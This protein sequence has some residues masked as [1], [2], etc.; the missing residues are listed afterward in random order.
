LALGS[1]SLT[2]VLLTGGPVRSGWIDLLLY[3]D[4]EATTGRPGAASAQVGSYLVASPIAFGYLNGR[5]V[6]TLG[7]PFTLRLTAEARAQSPQLVSWSQSASALV[8]FNLYEADGTPYLYGL[9]EAVPEPGGLVA[10]G[11]LAL[12][13]ARRW[14]MRVRGC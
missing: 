14:S 5:F 6:F 2:Y 11:L 3:L 1:V 13:V 8:G 12:A 10:G 9:E 7:E 4:G